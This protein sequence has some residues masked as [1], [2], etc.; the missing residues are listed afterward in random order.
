MNGVW[1][2][3]TPPARRF[4]EQAGYANYRLNTIV[5]GLEAVKTGSARKPADLAIHWES[6]DAAKAAEL[7]RSLATNAI[8]VYVVDALDSYMLDLARANIWI[9]D[10]RTSSL[11]SGE[12]QTDQSEITPLRP[13]LVQEFAS[14]IDSLAH[15]PDAL[16]ELLREFLPKH[17]GRRKRPSL[18]AKFAALVGLAPNV[19][20]HYDCAIQLLISWRNRHAHGRSADR[21]SSHVLAG[22][23]GA[24][25]LFYNDHAHLH[26]DRM[27]DNYDAGGSPTLKEVSS[28]I[29]V[30]HRVVALIDNT[31]LHRT[32]AHRAF[33]TALRSGFAE[34]KSAEARVKEYWGRSV[35]T[36]QTKLIAMAT[37]SG[38]RRVRETDPADKPLFLSDDQL[39]AIAGM[40][41]EEFA[42]Q[43]GVPLTAVKPQRARTA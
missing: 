34:E 36:R 39:R 4:R 40:A 25:S 22:L 3:R 8:M 13:R 43:I 41:R 33:L 1:V 5:V 11:L 20:T 27:I 42:D 2:Q 18:R 37:R 10:P 30:T 6:K 15:S 31:I 9:T 32:D 16:E 17:F 7:A 19:P 12:F 24:S 29:S 14:R 28:L 23:R 38:F 26:V 21:V 35:E